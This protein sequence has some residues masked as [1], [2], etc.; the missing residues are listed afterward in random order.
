MTTSRLLAGASGYSFKEWKGSFYPEKIKPE[1]MLAYYAERL[2]TVEINNTFYRMP[3]TAVLETWAGSTPDALPVRDQG[4]APDHP[5]RAD[6]GGDRGRAAGLSLPEPRGARRQARS[7]AVP[8]AAEPEKGPAAP[9]RV[10]PPAA[11]RPPRRVR[12][13]QRH[14][15]RRR[16]LRRAEGG[17]GGAVP[18]RAR[19]QRAAAAGGDGALGLCPAS[20]RDVLG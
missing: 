19:R 5:Y 17:R 11:R 1:E 14:L 13:S 10:S 9:H 6:Q 3:K 15:V 2:P 7:G 18:V 20:A 8:A 4:L 12:I 16:C